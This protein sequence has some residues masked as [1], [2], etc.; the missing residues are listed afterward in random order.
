MSDPTEELSEEIAQ[1]LA[2]EEAD[3]AAAMKLLSEHLN[4]I[5]EGQEE[6]YRPERG[7]AWRQLAEAEGPRNCSVEGVRIADEF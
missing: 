2:I 5:A 3:T 7:T 1:A 4:H 6:A